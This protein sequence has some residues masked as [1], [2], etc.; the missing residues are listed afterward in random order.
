MPSSGTI[1]SFSCTFQNSPSMLYGGSCDQICCMM[2]T[3]STTLRLRTPTSVWRNNSKSETRPP[4][5]TPSMKSAAAHVIELRRLGGDHDRV[6]IGETNDAGAELQIFGARYKPGHEHHRRGD[7]LAGRRKMLAQPNSAKAQLIGEERLLG[8][9]GQRFGERAGRRM[10]R[11]HEKSET[12]IPPFD[13]AVVRL[14]S[15]T[16]GPPLLIPLCTL[17]QSAVKGRK[18]K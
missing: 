11:H 9:L 1:V 12:H 10:H 18:P 14:C 3:D 8:I 16:V 15:A 2:R 13:A 5:P 17:A 6:V 4:G 7:R